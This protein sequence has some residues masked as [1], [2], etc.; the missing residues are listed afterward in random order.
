MKLSIILPAFN[1]VESLP[2]LIRAIS[3][4]IGKVR[5]EIIV[6]D[7]HSPDG[8]AKLIKKMF[9]KYKQVRVVENFKRT[10]LAPSIVRGIQYATGTHLLVMDSDFN[11][12]PK[13]IPQFLSMADTHNIIIGSRYIRGGGMENRLR[14]YMSFLYN[15]ILRSILKLPAHDNLSG[16]FLMKKN[17]LTSFPLGKIFRGYGDY[18]IRLLFLLNQK[19]YTIF[20]IPVYYENRF[21]G[22]SKSKLILMLFD[23]TKTILELKRTSI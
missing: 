3:E 1:E 9:R 13:Y 17:L 18:F 5:Y 21:A 23:Y 4:V 14:Y 15:G 11:H 8:T 16:Y 2:H 19:N 12:H 20:E 10:G 7:D 6:I 22:E